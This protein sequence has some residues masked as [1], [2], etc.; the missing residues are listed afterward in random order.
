VISLF[1]LKES[2]K[3][4]NIFVDI[5]SFP[6][7][8]I[9]SYY[10]FVRVLSNRTKI[11]SWTC[12]NDT[13]SAQ[14]IIIISFKKLLGEI[15]FRTQFFLKSRFLSNGLYDWEH[16]HTHFIKFEKS[17]SYILLINGPLNLVYLNVSKYLNTN[18]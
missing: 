13:L 7:I 14:L 6:C 18:K 1:E 17:N 2:L 4:F 10:C 12:E 3:I 9:I 8:Y 11:T 16:T 5:F 15:Y